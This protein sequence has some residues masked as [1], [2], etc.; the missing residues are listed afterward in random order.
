MFALGRR[1]PRSL[2]LPRPTSADGRSVAQN[3]SVKVYL[4]RGHITARKVFS[5]VSTRIGTYSAIFN[6]NSY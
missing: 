5:M 4:K 6:R 1:L 2:T 3:D